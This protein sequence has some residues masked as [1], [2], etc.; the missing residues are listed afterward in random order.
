MTWNLLRA[1][2]H[3][4]RPASIIYCMD[5]L[6]IHLSNKMVA[7]MQGFGSFSLHVSENQQV[8]NFSALY[9]ASN[10]STCRNPTPEERPTFRR[11][12]LDLVGEKRQVLEIPDP[13]LRSHPQ[14]GTLGAHLESGAL[15]YRDLQNSYR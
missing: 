3:A 11:T 6:K 13:D 14:A 9:N 5:E 1:I 15:M 4:A 2:S 8:M 12:V 10:I 7:T